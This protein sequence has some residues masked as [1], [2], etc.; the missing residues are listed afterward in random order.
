VLGPGKAAQKIAIH[1]TPCRF[2]GERPWFGCGCGR[3]VVNLCSPSG[4]RFACRRCYGLAYATQHAMPRDRN[5]LKA[6]KIQMGLGGSANM[7]DEFPERP[8]S[9]HW[10]RYNRLRALHDQ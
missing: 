2:G 5:L 3:S 10:K 9:M 4:D 6:Q 8:K 1:W 7:L